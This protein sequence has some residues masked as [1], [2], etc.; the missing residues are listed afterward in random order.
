MDKL[1]KVLYYVS[2]IPVF[3]DVVVGAIKGIIK[4]VNDVKQKAQL[5]WDL[6]QHSKFAASFKNPVSNLED[7]KK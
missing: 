2:I 3:T 6:E 1:K 5:E 4:G 7:T